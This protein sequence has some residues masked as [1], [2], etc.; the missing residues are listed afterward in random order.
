ATASQH[1]LET[2]IGFLRGGARP[3]LTMS[4][5]VAF[6]DA[7]RVEH[8]VESICRTLQDTP[9]QIAPS[10]Y[11][12]AQSRPPSPRA[13]RDAKL[14]DRISEIHAENYGVYG[15]RNIHGAVRRGGVYVAESA[16]RRLMRK[17]GLRGISRAKGRKT[18][19]PA[20]ET[21]RPMDLV[22]REF[23]ASCPNELWV[24]DITYVKTFSGGVYV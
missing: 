12:A 22:N 4:E 23:V 3:P 17:L 20:P 15:V 5:K 7:H 24:A 19:K 10:S 1:D 21:G 9:A 8:G 18:T 16:V 6:I 14:C 2:G 13:L 11:Y